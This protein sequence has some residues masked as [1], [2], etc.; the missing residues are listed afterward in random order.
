MT[1]HGQLTRDD[2]FFPVGW[3]YVNITAALATTTVVKATPGI[4]H[5]VIINTP[6]SSSVITLYDN[7]VAS[8]TKIG[9]ITVPA[10]PLPV[11]LVYDIT[12]TTGLSINT[13]TGTSDITIAYI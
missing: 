6:T 8:G 5:S 3:N 4:L 13:A 10:S 11:T 7:T 12:F 9:T 2:S 1:Y